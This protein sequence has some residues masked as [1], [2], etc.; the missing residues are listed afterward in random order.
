MSVTEVNLIPKAAALDA[1]MAAYA[2]GMK[3]GVRYPKAA[4]AMWRRSH[5]E[6]TQTDRK[7]VRQLLTEAIERICSED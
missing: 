6:Q 2:I 3:S 5:E 7:L 4:P 1:V